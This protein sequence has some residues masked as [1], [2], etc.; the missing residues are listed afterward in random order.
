MKRS[1]S[2]VL[3]SLIAGSGISLTACDGDVGGKPVEAQSYASVQECRAAGALSAVQCDTAFEQAKADAAK[4]GPRFEDRQT[5]EEQYGAAQCEPRNNGSGGSFFTPLLTGFLVGQALNGGFGA[6]G[7][8][9]YRDRDGNYYGGAGGRINRDYVT[10]RTR[11]GSDAFTPTTARAP[12]RVQSRS[13][14][15]SRGGFGGG[16]GGRSFGG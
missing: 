2:I 16:F 7:A 8:P 1:R 3:T 4:T 5:C 6:R 15:I 14:V 13:S 9:M 10:G 11:V 12:A